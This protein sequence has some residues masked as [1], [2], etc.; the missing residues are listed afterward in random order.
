MRTVRASSSGCLSNNARAIRQQILTI[1][2]TRKRKEIPNID[3]LVHR[4]L[5]QRQQPRCSAFKCRR[6]PKISRKTTI[7]FSPAPYQSPPV[8]AESMPSHPHSSQEMIRKRPWTL[9]SRKKAPFQTT[10]W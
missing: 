1:P 10:R 4:N 5:R 9:E 6:H 2:P 8:S 3:M 7:L